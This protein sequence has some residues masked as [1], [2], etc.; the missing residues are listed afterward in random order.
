MASPRW[1]T[2]S[3]AAGCLR[4]P[5]VRR[6]AMDL[7]KVLRDLGAKVE[8]S[9]VPD[10]PGEFPPIGPPRDHESEICPL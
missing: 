6:H 9:K 4:W 5:R 7:V 10:W 8:L 1:T 2:R 3:R